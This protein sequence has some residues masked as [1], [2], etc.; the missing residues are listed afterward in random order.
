MSKKRK[1]QILYILVRNVMFVLHCACVYEESVL[2][3]AYS[4]GA[5][6]DQCNAPSVEVIII[7]IDNREIFKKIH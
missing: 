5:T 3:F 7:G 1:N 4:I 6:L 2:I